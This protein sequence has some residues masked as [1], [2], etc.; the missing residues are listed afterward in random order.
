MSIEIQKIYE[1][2]SDEYDVCEVDTESTRI[3]RV[4][5][6]FPERYETEPQTSKH[7]DA[8]WM[9]DFRFGELA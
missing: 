3:L 6:H 8:G 2:D 5:S 9:N 1:P 4:I 7:C